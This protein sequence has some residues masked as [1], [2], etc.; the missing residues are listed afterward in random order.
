MHI[1]AEDAMVQKLMAAPNDRRSN[2]TW[3]EQIVD[4]RTGTHTPI[5][6]HHADRTVE[7]KHAIRRSTSA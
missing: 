6:Q 3:V 4:G 5:Y 7:L 2:T 1:R